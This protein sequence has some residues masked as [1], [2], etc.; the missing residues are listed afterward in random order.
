MP[1]AAGPRLQQPEA[2]RDFRIPAGTLASAIIAVGSQAGVSVATTE[3]ALTHRALRRSLRG[4]MTVEEALARVLHDSGLRAVRAA[5]GLYRIERI[6][7]PPRPVERERPTPPPSAEPEPANIVVT[8]S[9]RATELRHYAGSAWVLDQDQLMQGAGTARDSRAIVAALPMLAATNL[10]PG[11]EKLFVRGIADSSFTGASQATVG[12]YLGDVQL[13]YSAP[14]PNLALYDMARVEL[15]EGPQGTL[16]GAGALGG[17]VR[18]T[19][20]RPRPGV[21]E[22][23]VAGGATAVSHGGIGGDAMAMIN[24]PI[25]DRAALRLVGYGGRDPGYIDDVVRGRRNV[26]RTDLAGARAAL[27]YQAGNDWTIDIGGVYQRIYHADG[28]YTEA[29]DP[30][31]ARSAA[32]AQPA[33]NDFR[34]AYVTATHRWA[35]GQTLTAAFSAIEN[36]L[37]ALY[38]ATSPGDDFTSGISTD[39]RVRVYNGEIRLARHRDNGAGMVLGAYATLSEDRMTQSF[40]VAGID[41][42]FRGVGNQVVDVA[43]FGEVTV[44]ITPRLN[45]TI[46]GRAAYSD[47]QGTNILPGGDQ[48]LT[49]IDVPGAGN[50]SFLP[51]AAIGWAPVS[52]LTAYLRYQRGY[53]LGGYALNALSSGDP[54]APPPA[55][56]VVYRPDTVDMVEAGLRLGSGS[57]GLSGSVA[58]STTDWRHIQSDLYSV[59][60]PITANI[61]SGRIHGLEASLNWRSPSGLR[62]SGAL[63]LTRAVLDRPNPEFARDTLQALPNTPAITVRTAAEREWTL[64]GGSRLLLR[65][66]ARYIGRSWL[67]VGDLHLPQGNYVDANAAL[68]WSRGPITLTLDVANLLDGRGNRFSLGNPLSVQDGTQ[69]TPQQPRTLRLGASYRF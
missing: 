56:F 43:L 24:A 11:R 2:R 66:T 26:N 27:R 40:K 17:I 25:G 21:W 59:S 39:N 67:G 16:Y 62:L 29:G 46:G 58:L 20:H 45:A 42:P 34:L 55:G 14:D 44:P 36:H 49:T 32:I 4:R 12:Q 54:S 18:I 68:A 19:P 53:R 60:G 47:L 48:D 10:G 22:G 31:L 37:T 57:D 7:P 8:A 65:G 50:V 23:E 3:P 33:L 30:P 35:N 28:Q 38:D 6:P 61:G 69:R 15:L 63:F 1:A 52:R 64:R 41:Q 5:A 9:K 51:S 13:N